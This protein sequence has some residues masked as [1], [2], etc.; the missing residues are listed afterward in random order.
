MLPL[1]SNHPNGLTSNPKNNP[2]SYNRN[3]HKPPP[4]LATLAHAQ[5]KKSSI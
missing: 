1:N 3:L 5:P 2:T 4:R